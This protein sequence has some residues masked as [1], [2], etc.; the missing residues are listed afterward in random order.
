MDIREKEILDIL[1]KKNLFEA[2][3]FANSFIVVLLPSGGH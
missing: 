2:L 3:N 1:T